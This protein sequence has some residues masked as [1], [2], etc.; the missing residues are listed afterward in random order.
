MKDKC[1]PGILYKY[2]SVRSADELA[3]VI[4]I[5]RNRRI[6]F[7]HHDELNDPLEG[8]MIDVATG[9]MGKWAREIYDKE[10]DYVREI[11]QRFR[12]LS[13]SESYNNPLL[14]THYADNYMGVCLCFATDKSFSD[15]QS[16][17]Y[18]KKRECIQLVGDDTDIHK[19]KTSFFRKHHLWGYE[20]E[21]R[22]V[23]EDIKDSFLSFQGCE[24]TGIVFG[25]KMSKALKDC[26]M[27]SMRGESQCFKTY[28]G[29]RT[30]RVRIIPEN[31]E[32]VLD[33]R[34]FPDIDLN[35]ELKGS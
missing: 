8:G 3:R 1:V 35:T 16:V 26:I 33:G 21:W 28:I 5:I 24:L 32:I 11:K 20:G 14:W 9:Y 10:D 15:V 30:N 4:D 7:P 23:K 31:Y 22:I 19:V 34:E 27:D 2:K 13:F 12:I 17:I 29:Y 25:H 6:Y 18:C